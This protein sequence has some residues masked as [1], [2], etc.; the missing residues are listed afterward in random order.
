MKR[1]IVLALGIAVALAFACLAQTVD[2]LLGE[3]LDEPY[4]VVVDV[5]TT[6]NY[7]YLTD[8]VHN[9]LVRF[10][11]ATGELTDLTGPA[12][13]SPAGLVLARG[14]LVVAD[15]GAH[16]IR[17]VSFAGEIAPLAGGG[18]GNADGAG[19]AAQFNTPVGLALDSA[20]NIYVADSRNHTLRMIAPD[21]TVTTVATGFLRPTAVAVGEGGRL[22][23]AD[24]G[25]HVIKVIEP[26]GTIRVIA[27]TL[28][29]NVQASDLDRP[30]GLLWLGGST[31]L[32]VS[33]TGHHALRRVARPVPGR[34]DYW[35]TS[36]FAGGVGVAGATDGSWASARFFEPVGLAVDLNGAI[37]VADLKN[38]AIRR[39]TRTPTQTPVVTPPG[40]SFSNTV[41]V[42][43]SSL[44]TNA[45]FYYTTDGS[46]P[47]PASLPVA[48][49]L[50]FDGGPVG[51]KVRGFSPDYG[52]SAVIS[53]R[54]SF[55]INPLTVDPAGGFFTNDVYLA[56]ATVTSNVVIRYSL[57]GEPPSPASPVW[58]D[59][60]WGRT[61]PIKLQA[62]RDGFA[63]SPV[64]ELEFTFQIAPPVLWPPGPAAPATTSNQ[65]IPL[66]IVSGTSNVTFYW[67]FGPEEP[68]P[69][70]TLYTGPFDLG[71]NGVVQV[72]GYKAGYLDSMLVSATYNL[73]VGEV[74]IAPV[75]G[76]LA[77]NPVRVELATVTD[78]AQ[79]FWTID[80][81]DPTP[82][83][84][85][86][87]GP[88]DLGT[89]GVL[90]VRAFRDG[91]VPSGIASAKFDLLVGDPSIAPVGATN[92]NPV[93][94]TLASVT[95]GARIHWT[96]DGSDPTPNSLRYTDPFQLATNGV[97]R[98]RAFKDGLVPSAVVSAPFRLMAADPTLVPLGATSY[99]PVNVSMATATVGAGLYW[100]I[101]GSTPNRS[102]LVYAGPFVLATNGVLQ[103]RAIRDG[104]LESAVVS[105]PFDLSVAVPVVTPASGTNINAI[106]I[107]AQTATPGAELR[108]T[109]DGGNP[110]PTSPL[111]VG[112]INLT[113]NATFKIAGYRQGFFTS[114]TV[115]RDYA[116]K[117]DTPT[118]APD[119]GFFPD[120][121]TV[122]LSKIRADAVI[123]YTLDGT[124]PTTK[125]TR[126]T[127][128]FPVTA[129]SA[130]GADLRA[131][132]AR[133]FAPGTLPSDIVVGQAM[134]Q[135]S[136]GIPRDVFAGSGSS[137]IVPVV[138]NLTPGAVLKSLQMRVEV[139]PGAGAPPL[140]TD[141]RALSF[142]TNAFVSMV[143]TASAS[144]ATVFSTSAYELAGG[145]RGLVLSALGASANL[146]AT[147]FAVVAM[148]V[149][150]VPGGALEGRTYAI[151]I[152]E[153][154]GTADAS[155]QA[156]PL[157]PL[158]ARTIS[159]RNL[160][161]L[162]G[163][164][165]PGNWYN[166]GDFGNGDLDN[167]DVNNAFHASLGVRAPYSFTDAFDAMD[168]FPDDTLLS[169][170]GDGQIRFLDWQRILRRSLRL[171]TNNWERSWAV[172]GYRVA[173]ATTLPRSAFSI[174]A[175]V[176]SPTPAL[177]ISPLEAELG[178]AT[179]DQVRPGELVR[180]PIHVQVAP[181]ARL[182]GLQFRVLV[183]PDGDGP[184]LEV[185]IEFVKSAELPEAIRA[186]G[187]APNQV[188]SAWSP[189]LNPFPQPLVRR[190]ALGTINF[191]VPLAAQPA[192]VYRVRFAHADGAPDLDTP[193]GF[194]TTAGRV[195]VLTAQSAAA[196]TA[197]AP[198]SFRVRWPAVAGQRYL[199]E[200]TADLA[201]G[202]WSR[203]GTEFVGRG[204]A[205]EFIDRNQ[206]GA[207]KFYRVRVQR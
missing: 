199:V 104:F 113:T 141:L 28:G 30:R 126:Y 132:K 127:G 94:V 123:Y 44:T 53:N 183:E 192:Q 201:S 145:V 122:T 131:V 61:G 108:Y 20:G 54:F 166:A 102:S 146:T 136:V 75:T 195:T 151:D 100:T 39:L 140:A 128:P 147:D 26:G 4:G 10:A 62:Y 11:P 15:S 92:N 98:V 171:N 188:A 25:H 177:E 63:D 194:E 139:S 110:Q 97:L 205:L 178:A 134:P 80:G 77:Y 2:T 121:T 163:D 76:A 189:L 47:T 81:S 79:V 50:T 9:R 70:S 149:V 40:G 31:G 99:E 107:Q 142:D 161:Y 133:A 206:S 193:Y 37:V 24:T 181:G 150:P 1:T 186:S 38:H 114:P 204:A 159:V 16:A 7:Y 196:A 203:E 105:A 78:R 174:A 32:L 115:V 170:G 119:A 112:P 66:R 74:Q 18:A 164:S 175:A 73:L 120:G 68:T 93:E 82:N 64:T 191:T 58:T 71:T 202:S 185:P 200:S 89:N 148:L 168:A 160:R 59:R 22:F 111:Y 106:T 29:S 137:V 23:V 162:V 83:G 172:G 5:S 17:R 118:L 117:T 143:G 34:D 87:T 88:F 165:S 86:Y 138:V 155:Q 21:D 130:P 109:L 3:H 19:A 129:L 84:T 184:P 169:A 153:A 57:T 43:V 45:S 13:F 95:G 55:Y 180:V 12:F 167:A 51:F 116:I 52:A 36:T 8:S 90:K 35:V 14:G 46:D 158:P 41:S 56:A 103:V 187:L 197:P 190:V 198:R 42:A 125:S 49:A 207:A 173:T 154:S 85:L 65:S 60:V 124:D 152:R 182:A 101:D 176:E 156:L 48:G 135:N 91:F 157:A 96:I 33:D 144:A 72:R 6:N 69:A 179:I 27:G 67:S